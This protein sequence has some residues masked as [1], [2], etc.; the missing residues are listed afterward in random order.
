MKATRLLILACLLITVT[1]MAEQ[2]GTSLPRIDSLIDEAKYAEAL[3]VLDRLAESNTYEDAV[4]KNKRA[5]VLTAQ[6]YFA[7]SNRLLETIVAGDSFI[8]GLTLSNKGFLSLSQGRYDLALKHLTDSWAEFQRSGETKSREAILCLARLSS[9]YMSIG[10]YKKA[11]EHERLALQYREAM[12]GESSESVA[13]AY[14]N[15]GLIYMASDPG[16]SLGYYQKALAV[17]KRLYPISHPKIAVSNTNLGVAHLQ[18]KQFDEAIKCFELAKGIWESI[19][20]NGHPNIALVLRNLGRTYDQLKDREKSKNYYLR[21]VSMYETSYGTRNP[22]LASTFNELALVELNANAYRTALLYAQRSLMANTQNFQSADVQDNPSP[23]DYYNPG[24]LVHTL[25]LKA[26]ILE[27][28]YEAKTLRLNDLQLAL[29]CLYTCDSLIEDIRNKQAEETDKLTLGK[30]ANE[31]YE[32]GVRIAFRLSENVLNPTPYWEQAFF[33][34][35]RSK[36]SVLLAA[37]MESRAKSFSDIPPHVLELERSLKSSIMLLNQQLSQKP[38]V[39][40]EKKIRTQLFE[41]NSSYAQ[42]IQ[43]LESEYP[44]YYDLKYGKRSIQID[45]LQRTIDD[46]TTILSYFTADASKAL[47]VFTLTNKKLSVISR[48]LPDEFNRNLNGLKNG[49][50]F[51]EPVIFSK[52]SEWLSDL[53]L[54]HLPSSTKKLVI[55]PSGRLST[56]PFEVLLTKPNPS[57]TFA[58]AS[59]LLQRFS[60]SY[61][62]AASLIVKND[63]PARPD[64]ASIL[65]CAPITFSEGLSD[66]PATEK[67]VTKIATMFRSRAQ[68]ALYGVANEATIKSQDL[69]T[70]DYLHLATHGVADETSPDQSRLALRATPEEDGYLYT[71]EIYMLK[72]QARLAVLSACETGLGKISKGEGVIGLSRALIYAGAKNLVV[73]FWNV[74]DE[75]TALLMENFYSQVLKSNQDSFTEALR[76]SKLALIRQR[77][78][79]APYHWAPFV[80]VGR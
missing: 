18:L 68:V 64:S 79:S 26:K 28:Q 27:A 74:S 1:A 37:I 24:V 7:E 66:L 57:Q 51:S 14:N 77:T 61:E 32:D 3:V 44:N 12:F 63:R 67:E 42:L 48:S 76:A 5:E 72:L 21:A 49:I 60:I 25:N 78:Y 10:Q 34:S 45:D 15:L 9:V 55:I 65:L 6:G 56:L 30:V 70:F 22:D 71:G 11:E 23:S 16:Q 31:V 36:A 46:E 41:Q 38:D 50:L 35:E 4:L 13:A 47:F 39:E 52:T 54:P 40:V 59:Y 62:F 53:L 58:D 19:Y 43:Q 69:S 17:Y 8:Q 29:R 73:S 80:L 2:N 20:P 75:S 33:F